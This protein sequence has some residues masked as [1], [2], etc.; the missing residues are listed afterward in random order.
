MGALEPGGAPGPDPGRGPGSITSLR[1]G[2]A[3]F[4]V[5]G[6]VEGRWPI[7]LVVLKSC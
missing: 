1:D 5:L 4:W 2:S 3:S 7:T 6:E